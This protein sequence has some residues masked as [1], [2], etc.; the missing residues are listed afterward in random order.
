[1]KLL[2][3]VLKLKNLTI[4]KKTH[5]TIFSCFKNKINERS[6]FKKNFTITIYIFYRSAVWFTAYIFTAK[7]GQKYSPLSI[8]EGVSRVTYDETFVYAPEVNFI[9]KGNLYIKEPYIVEYRNLPTPFISETLPAIILASF[10]MITG[11]ISQAFLASDFIFPVLVFLL[12]FFVAR[13]FVENNLYALV[14]AF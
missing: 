10:S 9:L 1:M 7:L 12:F 2:N 5:S 13:I 11:S 14:A 3:P 4:L 6:Y 8:R